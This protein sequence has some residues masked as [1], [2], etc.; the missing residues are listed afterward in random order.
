MADCKIREVYTGIAA[1]ISR[2]T[3][4][5]RHG[6]RSRKKKYRQADIDRVLET[7]SSISLPGDQQILHI[8]EQEFCIDGQDGT[9]SR[10]V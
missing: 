9:R 2:S 7:P 10:W 6:E 5:R 8:L 4:S 3:N 1:A